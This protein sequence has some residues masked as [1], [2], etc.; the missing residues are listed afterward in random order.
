[1][2]IHWKIINIDVFQKSSLWIRTTAG[3]TIRNY[4]KDV[5]LER[6]LEITLNALKPFTKHIIQLTVL[7]QLPPQR[8][9]CVI[10]HTVSLFW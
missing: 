1:M 2:L 6:H 3:L 5:P 7:A 8:D 9:S 4:N 10:D